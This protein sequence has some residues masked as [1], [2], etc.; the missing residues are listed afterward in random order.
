M[1][2]DGKSGKSGCLILLLLAGIFA[3]LKLAGLI[4]W[5][6]WWVAAPLWV[7]VAALCG[8]MLAV[9]MFTVFIGRGK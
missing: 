1:S 3:A 2:D 5:S 9:L 7:P 8:L 6:W 4:A